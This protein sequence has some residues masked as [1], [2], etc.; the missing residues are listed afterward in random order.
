MS[1]N[2][3][4]K[5]AKP[6]GKL[7]MKIANAVKRPVRL[8]FLEFVCVLSR[9]K[10]WWWGFS[11]SGISLSITP[12]NKIPRKNT[13]I[14][15]VSPTSFIE[16]GINSIKDMYIITPAE[17]PRE[18]E[19]YFNF[20][21][22]MQYAIHPPNVVESPARKVRINAAKTLLNPSILNLKTLIF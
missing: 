8:I 11:S 21:F 15:F 13:Q 20:G 22:L 3:A 16:V 4:V 10:F 2:A 19:R 9:F 14:V 7:W 6:S 5:V 1:I 17:K 18:S 12:M